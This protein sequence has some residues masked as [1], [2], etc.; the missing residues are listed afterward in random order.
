[1]PQISTQGT[2]AAP[3]TQGLVRNA[4]V[5]TVSKS[6]MQ[7]ADAASVNEMNQEASRRYLQGQQAIAQGKSLQEVKDNQSSFTSL[8]GEGAS[9]AG[10]RA[11]ATENALDDA[12]RTSLDAIP[13]NAHLTPKEY[14]AVQ[15][16][17]LAGYIDGIKDEKTRQA[18]T[19]GFSKKSSELSAMH[20]KSHAQYIDNQNAQMYQKQ[21]YSKGQSAQFSVGKGTEAEIEAN[22]DLLNAMVKPKGM[23]TAQYHKLMTSSVVSSLE[24]GNGA[25]YNTMIEMDVVKDLSNEQRVALHKAYESYEAEQMKEQSVVVGASLFDLTTLAEDPNTDVSQLI[26]GISAHQQKY[27]MTPEKVNTILEKM[28]TA[29]ENRKTVKDTSHLARTRQFHLIS[30]KNQPAALDAMREEFGDNYPEYWAT[31]GVNDTT[32]SKRWTQSFQSLVLPDGEVDP[33]FVETAQEF[34]QYSS[35]DKD[36]AFAHI[37][38]PKAKA[39]IQAVLSRAAIDGDLV[40]AVRQ[41]SLVEQ[42]NAKGGFT[43]ET[44]SDIDDAVKGA[45]SSTIMPNMLGG[46][47]ALDS[48]NADYVSATIKRQTED[49]ML[50]GRMDAEDAAEVARMDFERTH[51]KI[52]GDYIPNGGESFSSRL[53][54]QDGRTPEA[55]LDDFVDT[56][57]EVMFGAHEGD[58]STVYNIANNS[59]TFVPIDENGIPTHG[60]RTIS[61]DAMKSLNVLAHAKEEAN[62]LQANALKHQA[63]LDSQILRVKLNYK[64]RY[65]KELTDEQALAEVNKQGES[66]LQMKTSVVNAVFQAM[67][68][69]KA[70]GAAPELIRSMAEPSTTPEQEAT[71]FAVDEGVK[72][73]VAIPTRTGM[74]WGIESVR[75]IGGT[76]ENVG[77][78]LDVFA[79]TESASGKFRA[80]PVSSARGVFQ[81]MTKSLP[82]GNNAMQT[83]ITRALRSY[84]EGAPSW[85]E[86]AKDVAFN[87][88]DQQR[89][90]FMM[91]L[92]DDKSA[93]LMLL[94]FQGRPETASLLKKVQDGDKDAIEELYFKY[95]HTNPDEATTELFHRNMKRWAAPSKQFPTPR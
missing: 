45:I 68:Q 34:M 87:G 77:Y 44:Q 88:T 42:N 85:L 41:R 81:Y 12:Y 75:V 54:L 65:N 70:L 31:I 3:D 59:M 23:G 13:S 90:Y 5:Q 73:G 52:K 53:G 95:H 16:D 15:Q 61:I 47:D 83:A 21:L 11:L 6:L 4:G 79:A 69:L 80:N 20:L 37:N 72:Y 26:E 17:E 28:R 60:G 71:Q 24:E 76:N 10:A 91:T 78:M 93:A 40:S 56:N 58:Y 84:P 22:R 63:T 27:G 7:F 35:I 48:F 18:I 64:R 2:T 50:N 25:L 39:R 9:V 30:K 62:L 19:I 14:A 66:R 43:P 8:F 57:R 29:Q 33:R 92:D 86:D 38:D 89:E 82:G 74:G 49:Y 36:R 55:A 94:D 1:M 67:P 32:L 51:E 46:H